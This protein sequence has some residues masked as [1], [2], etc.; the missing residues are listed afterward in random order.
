MC[1]CLL[2][3]YLCSKHHTH[4]T[5]CKPQ[6]NFANTVPYMCCEYMVVPGGREG[7]YKGISITSGVQK[8]ILHPK[9]DYARWC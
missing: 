9:T 8:V 3:R 5:S 6:A 1:R 4:N 7:G 2:V